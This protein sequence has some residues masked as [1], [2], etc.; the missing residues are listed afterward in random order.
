MSVLGW[1]LPGGGDAAQQD[2]IALERLSILLARSAPTTPRAKA[3]MQLEISKVEQAFLPTAPQYDLARRDALSWTMLHQTA[4]VDRLAEVCGAVQISAQV[5]VSDRAPDPEPGQ[6][7]LRGRARRNTARFEQRLVAGD[8]LV[9][10][11]RDLPALALSRRDLGGAA[12]LDVLVQRAAAEDLRQQLA[13]RLATCGQE[14]AVA[15]PL[16]VYG[17]TNVSEAMC[18]TI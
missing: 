13:L 12:A 5:F 11:G 1:C 4:L 3:L 16:P 18:N 7:W 9:Q 17:F 8:I 14:C 15:G 6:S 2:V 10:V